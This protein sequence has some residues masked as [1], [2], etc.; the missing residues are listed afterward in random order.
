MINEA[1][2]IASLQQS[3]NGFIGDDAAVMPAR[4]SEHFVITKD[5]LIEDIHFRTDYFKPGDLA[6]KALHVN[7]SDLAAMGAKPLYALCGISI[8]C[9]L[10]DYGKAFL[11]QLAVVCQQAGVILI[12]GDT[13]ASKG[14]LFISMTAVGIALAANL[15]YRDGAKSGDLICVAGDLGF[16]HIGLRGLELSQSVDHRCSSQFLRPEAKTNEG[17]WLGGRNEVSSM[18]DISDGL[19]VDLKRLAASSKKHAV[20]DIELLQNDLPPTVSVQTALEGGEDYGLLITI[21]KSTFEKFSRDFLDRFGYDLKP[22]GY[23]TD[24]GGVSFKK[25]AKSMEVIVNHFAHFGEVE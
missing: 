2:L 21:S 16:A 24:G 12:G 19:Y 20:I 13:T 14:Q 23:M 15:K 4:G 17:I 7:L 22:V 1:Q 18:M 10:H 5:L 8:P 11:D 3:S 6:H 25:G 9:N